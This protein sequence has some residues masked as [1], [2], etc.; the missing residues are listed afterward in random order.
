MVRGLRFDDIDE[1]DGTKQLL[2]PCLAGR[3]LDTATGR[4]AA[5]RIGATTRRR[6]AATTWGSVFPGQVFNLPP[7]PLPLYPLRG[8]R[9]GPPRGL[10]LGKK[11]D[12]RAAVLSA[13]EA[14]TRLLTPRLVYGY[15]AVARKRVAYAAMIGRGIAR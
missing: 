12:G 10:T 4:T 3:Q 13:R 2:L 11:A 7:G 6:A 5:W 1:L 8:A 9:G 14:V 15:R